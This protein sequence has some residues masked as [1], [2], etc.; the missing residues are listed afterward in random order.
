MKTFDVVVIGGGPGG[1]V[2]AIE[3][4]K[5]GLTV[6][7]V[8]KD[9]LGG[10]CLNRGCIPS[11]TLLRFAEAA[12]LIAKAEKWGIH[13]GKPEFDVGKMMAQKNQVIE[14]LRGGVASLLRAGKIEHVRGLGTVR[15]DRT[16]LVNQ[17][18]TE[19]ILQARNV[20]LAT[21]SVPSLPPIK[22]LEQAKVQTSDT[23]FDMERIVKSLVIVGGGVIGV[24]FA[25]IYSAFGAEVTLVEMAER[26]IPSEDADAARVLTQALKKNRVRIITGAKVEEVRE[27]G[28]QKEV[29][30]QTGQSTQT[31]VAEEI[32]VASGRKANWNGLEQLDLPKNRNVVQVN[33]YLET[34]IKGIYA[35]GDLIGGWQLAHVASAEGTVAAANIAGKRRKMNYRVVPRCIY[36]HPE[37]ASVG[38]SLEEANRQGYKARTEVFR[39]S[40]NGKALAMDETDGFVKLIVDEKYGEVLG[41]VMVGP[42]VTEMISEVSAFIALEGTIEEMASMIHPHPTI[43]ESL[44][45]AAG[46]LDKTARHN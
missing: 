10:T 3:A 22:G 30:V 4:A 5:H 19:V 46:L 11:K 27:N 25:C 34:G 17:D 35:V 28:G 18:G 23:I 7:L 9:Q 39:L 37:I 40:A 12:E 38:I 41:A 45:E 26:L 15:P 29:L 1:Y 32:L 8:E 6:A 33:E 31:L 43:S 21:G 36:S 2:A 24:E 13:A 14:R 16:I 44:M 20:I 42:H